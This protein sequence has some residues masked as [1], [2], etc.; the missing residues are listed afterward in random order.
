M[1]S[2]F[3]IWILKPDR[4]DP[5]KGAGW[6]NALPG[7]QT[8]LIRLMDVLDGRR[9]VRSRQFFRNIW[10]PK[11]SDLEPNHSLA[12]RDGKPSESSS[13]VCESVYPTVGVIATKRESR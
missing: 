7:I 2:T 11:H 1:N 9:R 12:A 8:G 3:S 13:L 6:E 5:V 10:R 4:T